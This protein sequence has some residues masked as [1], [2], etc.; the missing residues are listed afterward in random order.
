MVNKDYHNHI[1]YLVKGN[2][3]HSAY[4]R[5][6]SET[7][8]DSTTAMQMWGCTELWSDDPPPKSRPCSCASRRRRCS[9]QVVDECAVWR[10]V[11]GTC[12]CDG[13]APLSSLVA[14]I[15]CNVRHRTPWFIHSDLWLGLRSRHMVG[16]QSNA[17][18]HNSNLEALKLAIKHAIPR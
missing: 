10:R 5:V 1:T 18:R 17:N 9:A 2:Y 4:T 8:D 16:W 12:V 6:W 15:F 11:T 13:Q 14:R 3:S 7:G